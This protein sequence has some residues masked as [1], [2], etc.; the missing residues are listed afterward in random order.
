M[1]KPCAC[2]VCATTLRA[3]FVPWYQHSIGCPVRAIDLARG[4]QEGLNPSRTEEM[5]NQPHLLTELAG[6]EKRDA[7]PETTRVY[8]DAIHLQP[9][10]P[11]VKPR[12]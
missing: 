9:S 3:E 1:L 11:A 10:S 4:R 7:H 5:S 6:Q 12:R 2:A 8:L